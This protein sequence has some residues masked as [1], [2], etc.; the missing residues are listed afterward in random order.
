MDYGTGLTFVK[1]GGSLITDKTQPFTTRPDVI[2]RLVDELAQVWDDHQGQLVLGHGSGSFGHTT[3]D[4]YDLQHGYTGPRQRAGVAHTQRAAA[5]LHRTVLEALDEAG[6]PAFS[7]APSSA[8]ITQDGTPDDVFAEPVRRA[9]QLGLLPVVYGDVALDRA[10]GLA[11]ASTEAV[12]RG[13]I[14]ALESEG[15]RTNR[16]LWLGRTD[17]IYDADGEPIAQVDGHN[18]EAVWA[19]LGPPAGT[20]VTGG[21][22]LRLQTALDLA[23]SGVSSCIMNGATAGALTRALRGQNVAG[24]HVRRSEKS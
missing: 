10:Q 12:F 11:I 15:V 19:Q 24:T 18:A 9:L 8:L 5:Q 23:N 17:G 13:L 3:A 22:Q 20:D 2:H 6:L 1:W 16:V 21:M 4:E 14:G 7:V